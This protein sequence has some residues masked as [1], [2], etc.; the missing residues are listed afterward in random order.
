MCSNVGSFGGSGNPSLGEGGATIII[1]SRAPVEVRR[2]AASSISCAN[3]KRP[4]M[5]FVLTF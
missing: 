1:T 4:D 5:V 3:T 2:V